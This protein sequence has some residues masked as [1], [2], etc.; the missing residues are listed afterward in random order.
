MPGGSI[1]IGRRQAETERPMG[2]D[3]PIQLAKK[4]RDELLTT[5]VGYKVTYAGPVTP[6]AYKD[7]ITSPMQFDYEGTAYTG[8]MTVHLAK[9]AGTPDPEKLGI[10]QSTQVEFRLTIYMPDLDS[11]TMEWNTKRTGKPATI[12]R[13][14]LLKYTIVADRLETDNDKFNSTL[15]D[16]ATRWCDI[17]GGSAQL[18][19]YQIPGATDVQEGEVRTQ[20]LLMTAMAS[21]NNLRLSIEAPA[22][23]PLDIK[24][25]D[26]N[27]QM[28]RQL[29]AQGLTTG[30]PKETLEFS[31]DGLAAGNYFV[32]VD[33]PRGRA[34]VPII[35]SK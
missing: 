19:F 20:G 35:L 7:G 30:Q 16:G 12:K 28:V 29:G 23:T 31:L 33:S 22:G 13:D 5:L 34:S 25:Y 18:I 10:G 3:Q 1:L 4:G 11:K 9:V 32:A 27:G 15:K 14:G 8:N 2:W 21:G 26:I 24:L 17:L 6:A